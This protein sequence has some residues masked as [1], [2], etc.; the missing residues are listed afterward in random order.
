MTTCTR[1]VQI[2]LAEIPDWM[3]EGLMNTLTE[4]LLAIDG[5]SREEGH[6]LQ[7]YGPWKIT[8]VPA[9]SP[10]LISTGYT[11]WSWLIF[12]NGDMLG[13]NSSGEG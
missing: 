9:D 13:G 8:N 2:K 3:K 7:G 11:Q 1:S 10:T 6:F 5:Y 4:E 12:K